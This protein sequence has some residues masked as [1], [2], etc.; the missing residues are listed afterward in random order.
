MSCGKLALLGPS[1][2]GYHILQQAKVQRRY[3]GNKEYQIGEEPILH[4]H[5]TA[6]KKT[7]I[8]LLL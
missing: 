1:D 4:W 2:H 3:N 8:C 6:L 5:T 7:K